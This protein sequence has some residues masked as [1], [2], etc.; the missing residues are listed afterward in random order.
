GLPDLGLLLAE[1]QDLSMLGALSV[2]I[3][4]SPTL[5]DAM[6]CTSRYLFI[7]AR[8]LSVEVVE[9]PQGADGVMG[10]RYE[11]IGL[12]DEYRQGLDVGLGFL[13]RMMRF[14]LSGDYGLRGVELSHHPLAP[15][16]RYEEFFGARVL[17]AR[18]AAVL[19]VPVSLA[20]RRIDEANQAVRTVAL[21]YLDQ[22]GPAPG[23]GAAAQVEAALRQSLGTTTVQM[24]DV[25]ALL[26]VHPRTLQRQLDAEGTSFA[27]ILDELRRTR[28][29]TYLTTSDMPM[30]QIA[31]ALGLSEQSALSRSCRRW[32]D[33]SPSEIRAG[34]R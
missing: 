32:W 9:D 11:Q 21:A 28:A 17:T 1:R 23:R 20:S 5:G 8:G 22:H 19:R 31:A 3:Q 18:P 10:V 29:R 26:A 7:H 12:G 30:G 13:H 25:A 16:S 15:V 33:Q 27:A 34:R 14:L 4:N 2:A 6:E 24:A